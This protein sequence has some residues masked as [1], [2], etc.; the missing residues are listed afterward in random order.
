[1]KL[2]GA[3]RFVSFA[4]VLLPLSVQA[5]LLKGYG[6]KAGVNSSNTALSIP[7]SAFEIDTQRRTGVNAAL[8]IEWGGSS[9]YSLVTQVEYAQRGFAEE[10]EITGENNPEPLGKVRAS[11]RL[12]YISLP[13]LLKLQ[14]RKLAISPYLIAGPRV[15]FLVNREV[16]E[17]DFVIGNSKVSVESELSKIVDDRALGGTVGLG[18]NAQKFLPLPLL[19]EGRYN[20]D[21]TDNSKSPPLQGKNNSFDV[22]LGIEF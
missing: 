17:F 8:F 22:W 1:M 14:Y 15:D 9:F 4:A 7:Q 5:Q 11:T 16:G 19:V 2:S 18:F 12:D 13:I 21:F 20:F 10:Q 3:L 6:I